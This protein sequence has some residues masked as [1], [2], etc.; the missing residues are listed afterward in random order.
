MKYSVQISDEVVE[1]QVTIGRDLAVVG[2]RGS[3][4]SSKERKE[5]FNPK[6]SP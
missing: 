6:S 1:L 2:Q 5:E 4:K 3:I